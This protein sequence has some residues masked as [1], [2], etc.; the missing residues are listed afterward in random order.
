[1]DSG[2]LGDPLVD[3]VLAR[4]GLREPPRPT[5]AGLAMLYRAWCEQVPWDNVQK[6][7]TIASER[8]PLG[9][10]HPGEFLESF[11]RDGTGG[12]CWPG[13]GALHALLV[14]LGFAARRGVGA[15]DHHRHGT[16]ENHAT[17]IVRLDGEDLVVDS[18]LLHLEPLPLH[19]GAR[20]DDP[21]H[22]MR[23]E[24][25]DGEFAIYWTMHSRD[26]EMAFRLLADDVPL[27][28]YLDRYEGSRV[29]GFSYF[30]SFAK[31]VPGGVLSL[32]GARRA[33]RGLD[34]LLTAGVIPDRE[35]V[36]IEEGGLSPA[37]VAQLPEDQPDP[38]RPQLQAG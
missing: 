14:H 19:D 37:V 33:F 4:F 13:S 5:R 29:T 6:R 22:R 38:Y 25:A 15:M 16:V 2:E 23:V 24:R 11:L 7:I 20:L 26:T 35:R 9:G 3:R 32:T 18:S 36:L 17:T 12:T 1:M 10:A 8:A 28:Y 34:G 21:A 27:A 31:V 30:L